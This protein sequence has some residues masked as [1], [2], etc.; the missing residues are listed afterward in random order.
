MLKK[1]VN[2]EEV[3][4]TIEEEDSIQAEWA[5][6]E[7]NKPVLIGTPSLEELIAKKLAENT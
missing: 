5:H 7:A 6:N 4:C 2:G 1:I 3:Q